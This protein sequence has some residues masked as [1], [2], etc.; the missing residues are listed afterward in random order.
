MFETFSELISEEELLDINA[1]NE[2]E[3]ASSYSSH[4]NDTSTTINQ[5]GTV[6]KS[7]SCETK[8]LETQFHEDEAD[9]DFVTLHQKSQSSCS[10]SKT[11]KDKKEKSI[12][13]TKPTKPSAKTKSVEGDKSTTTTLRLVEQRNAG[14][15]ISD[16]K[17]KASSSSASRLANYL[18]HNDVD[19][20]AL[21][22]RFEETV[23]LSTTDGGL[24]RP[25]E[26]TELQNELVV[27]NA[28]ESACGWFELNNKEDLEDFEHF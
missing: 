2:D 15:L 17:Q 16:E 6:L 27:V 14:D 18:L 20:P 5:S 9:V 21:L 28:A 1:F 12:T 19:K 22:G 26:R 23:A 7:L 10:S 3:V 24:S 4:S 11:K 25:R 13:N 8:I